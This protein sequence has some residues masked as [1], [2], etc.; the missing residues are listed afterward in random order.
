MILVTA[1][2]KGGVGKTTTAA[3]LYG[4]A[5]RAGVAARLINVD[6]Q[7]SLRIWLG[8][9]VEHRPDLLTPDA[10]AALDHDGTLTI[11]DTPAGT[12][13]QSAAACMAADV[14][15]GCTGPLMLDYH[16]LIDLAERMYGP[17]H[18]DLVA[19]GRFDARTAEG[20]A[21][22]ELARRRFG[23]RK[24]V[25]VPN[26]SEVGRAVIDHRD[27][28]RTSPV[29]LAADDLLARVLDLDVAKKVRVASHHG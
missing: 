27:V 7:P 14:L 9:L 17:E 10:L 29:A 2:G 3:T 13:D 1:S 5:V 18:I 19:V 6:P 15:I 4:A 25:V 22:V 20:L 21:V 28:T 23:A 16:G 11:V 24:V 12:A 26:R 8:D